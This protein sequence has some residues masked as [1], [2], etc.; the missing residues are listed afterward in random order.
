VPPTTALIVL[1][2]MLDGGFLGDGNAC[3]DQSTAQSQERPPDKSTVIRDLPSN[4]WRL[5]IE[6]PYV[7]D[8]ARRLI[9]EAAHWLS[10][11]DCQR[12]FLD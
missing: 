2:S 10:F 1:L 4:T 5:Y 8:A 9:E 7:R 6:D 3:L 11:P 12:L